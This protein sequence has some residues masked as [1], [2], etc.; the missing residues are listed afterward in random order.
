LFVIINSNLDLYI[1]DLEDVDPEEARQLTQFLKMDITGVGLNFTIMRT[2]FGEIYEVN[3]K[4]GGS[5][6][7]VDETN[8]KVN[9]AFNLFLK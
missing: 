7:E 1:N 4:K 6:I 9:L 3:L 2:L 8:K 5:E